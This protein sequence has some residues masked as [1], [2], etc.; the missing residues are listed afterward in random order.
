[1]ELHADTAQGSRA[2]ADARPLIAGLAFGSSTVPASLLAMLAG[3]LFLEG[4][5]ALA[6]GLGLMSGLVAAT[7]LF[8]S[9]FQASGAA[10]IPTYLKDRFGPAVAALGAIVLVLVLLLLLVAELSLSGLAAERALGLPYAASVIAMAAIVAAVAAL[11]GARDLSPLQ[12]ALYVV[13]ATGLVIALLLVAAPLQGMTLPQL[14]YGDALQDIA[15]AERQLLEGGLADL[16][17]FRPHA[18]PFLDVDE[19][20]LLALF[21]TLMAGT[22]A[23][24]H[25]VTRFASLPSPRGARLAGA[26]AAL[27]VAVLLVTLPALAAFAKLAIFKLILAPTP[28]ASLPDWLQRLSELDLVRVHGASLGM[29]QDVLYA[30][31]SGQ[32]D[33]A[34]VTSTLKSQGVATLDAWIALKA[35][36]KAVLVEQAKHIATAS[37][38]DAWQTFKASVLPAVAQVSGNKTGALTHSGLAIDAGAVLFLLPGLTNVAVVAAGLVVAATLAAALSTSAGL[39]VTLADAVS[40]RLNV[41]RLAAVAC[42]A[43]AGLVALVR[44]PDLMDAVMAAFSIAA[45]GLFPVLVVGLWSKRVN[46]WGAAAGLIAGLAVTLLYLAG[47]HFFPATFYETW[48]GLSNASDVAV[49]KFASL[50][51]AWEKAQA[52]DA[53]AAAFLALETHARGIANWFGIHGG[54]AAIFGVPLGFAVMAIVSLF[55]PRRSVP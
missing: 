55:A 45:A 20:N 26:W 19:L 52:G 29:F 9:R 25:V 21:V 17:S 41:I 35:P 10:T 31:M 49:R 36:A 50:K 32:M 30:V 8:A 6:Y 14:S 28:F 37:G 13:L 2:G 54:S 16:R 38:V 3:L 4:H 42:V 47:T 18:K 44:P 43:L 53:K 15:A 48:P 7:V 46:A 33:V 22:A 39:T 5:D 34:G 27:F 1:V 11:A 40:N 23:L 12:A 51:T 24:P